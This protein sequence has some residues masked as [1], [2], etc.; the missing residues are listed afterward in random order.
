MEKKIPTGKE[1]DAI[2]FMKIY[3]LDRGLI[4]WLIV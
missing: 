3:R 1:P 2:S 4:K